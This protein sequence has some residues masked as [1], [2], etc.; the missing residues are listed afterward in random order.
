MYNFTFI[1][2]IN[3]NEISNHV[4]EIQINA[5]IDLEYYI[6]GDFS[7]HYRYLFIYHFICIPTL[8]YTMTN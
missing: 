2:S 5:T 3:D 8:Q 1:F 7:E 4:K 6:D